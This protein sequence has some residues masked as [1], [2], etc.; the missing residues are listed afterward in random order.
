MAHRVMAAAVVVVFLVPVPAR[1]QTP[2]LQG[3]WQHDAVLAGH[4]VEDGRNPA[5]DIITGEYLAGRVSRSGE[6]NPTVIVEPADGRIPY[7][8]TAAVKRDE[9]L[10][11][12]DTPTKL[13]HIDPHARSLLDGVP[14]ANYDPVGELQIEQIP[15]YVLILYES[16]HA[17]RAI[18][19]D[20]RPHLNDG[21]Q[22]FMGDSRGRWEGQT[23]VVDVTNFNDRTWF[24]THGTFHSDALH[25]VERWTMVGPDQIAYEVAIEDPKVFTSPWKMAFNMNRRTERDYEQWEV[26]S[27]EGD[28]NVEQMLAGG[29]REKE[30]GRTGIHEHR[31]AK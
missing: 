10:G 18:P 17:F 21:V 16:G 3:H 5:N 27:V 19:I 24:D 9:F 26:A 8:S 13:E 14:R 23:L 31:R 12:F 6:R 29:R 2:D 28:R 7:Q 20:G 15:G 25:V 1:G 11:N 22:L 30:A 4:S